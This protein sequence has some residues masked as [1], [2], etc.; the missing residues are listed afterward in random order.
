M[1]FHEHCHTLVQAVGKFGRI[2]DFPFSWFLNELCLLA[3]WF[4][5]VDISEDRQIA[6][7]ELLSFLSKS[8]DGNFIKPCL[9]DRKYF[10]CILIGTENL[11]KTGWINILDNPDLTEEEREEMKIKIEVNFLWAI[12]YGAQI[13]I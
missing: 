5:N 6:D 1:W 11:A 2:H 13:E 8:I 7:D 9:K 12:T 4:A 3:S 10:W